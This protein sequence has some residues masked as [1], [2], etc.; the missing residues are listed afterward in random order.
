M[1]R[2][3][4]SCAVRRIYTSLGAKRLNYEFPGHRN[5]D[6]YVQATTVVVVVGQAFCTEDIKRRAI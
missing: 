4:F 5:A 1:Q 6:C 3:E 2:L